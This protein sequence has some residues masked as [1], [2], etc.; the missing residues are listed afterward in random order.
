MA[1]GFGMGKGR[2]GGGGAKEMDGAV[3]LCPRGPPGDGKRGGGGRG[4]Y[5][6]GGR[7]IKK[8]KTD[9]YEPPTTYTPT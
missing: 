8:K 2:E 5:P 1:I 9:T 7:I 3:F 6:G 4:V